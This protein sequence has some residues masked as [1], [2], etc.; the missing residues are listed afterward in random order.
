MAKTYLWQAPEFP[1][2]YYNPQG[3]GTAKWDRGFG[4]LC[5]VRSYAIK[6]CRVDFRLLGSMVNRSSPLFDELSG[7]GV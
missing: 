7:A 1:H 2:F 6:I 5:L 3:G 4:A